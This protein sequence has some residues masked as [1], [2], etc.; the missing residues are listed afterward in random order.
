MKRDLS[1]LDRYAMTPAQCLLPADANRH[2]ADGWAWQINGLKVIASWGMG[3]DHVSVSLERRCPTWEE[4][5][6]IKSQFFEDE[7][8]VI[9]YHPPK[10]EYVNNH[11]HCLHMWRPHD[12]EIP[13]PPKHFV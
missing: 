8:C 7:E 11:P 6:W 1:H 10:S 12:A 5:C 9:Q 3:W 4:M 2:D 13:L